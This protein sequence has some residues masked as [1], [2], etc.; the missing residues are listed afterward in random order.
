MYHWSFHFQFALDRSHRLERA[1]SE[2]RMIARADAAAPTYAPPE[3]RVLAP[4]S[5]RPVVVGSAA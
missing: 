3:L 1:A 5:S 4:I 2:Y